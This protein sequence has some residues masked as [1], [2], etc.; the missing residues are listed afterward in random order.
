MKKKRETRG[1]KREGAGRKALPEYL[2][3][4]RAGNLR[5]TKYKIDA[6]KTLSVSL[7]QAIEQALDR[8]Y[9]ELFEKQR[10]EEEA[11]TRDGESV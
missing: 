9:G 6:L 5:I 2:Q 7:G 4:I 10:I 8:M 1:G 11:K 3:K